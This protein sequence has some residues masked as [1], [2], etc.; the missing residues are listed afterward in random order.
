M[1]IRVKHE[2]NPI[3]GRKNRDSRPLYAFN[4]YSRPC[5]GFKI[6]RL[7]PLNSR[8]SMKFGCEQPF[9][10]EVRELMARRARMARPERHPSP[11][12]RRQFDSDPR[13]HL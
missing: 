4:R 2:E 8:P 10:S 13:L 7:L 3:L 6:L 9:R 11:E 1:R 5:Y 12:L